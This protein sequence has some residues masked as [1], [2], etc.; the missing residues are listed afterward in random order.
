MHLLDR[1]DGSCY[2]FANRL[3]RTL[4]IELLTNAATEAMGRFDLIQNDL[5]FI[6]KLLLTRRIFETGRFLSRYL[7]RT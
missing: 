4:G 3:S 2:R 5:A 1:F 6:P 7:I